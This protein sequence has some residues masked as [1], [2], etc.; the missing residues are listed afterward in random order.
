MAEVMESNS[1]RDELASLMEDTGIRFPAAGGDDD[2]DDA[3]G[4]STPAFE[5]KRSAAAA[6]FLFPESEAAKETESFKEQIKGFGKAW[7]EL[8]MELGRGCKEV[9]QQS[10]LTE[11]SYIVRKTKGPLS[12]VSKRLRFVNEYLPEDKDPVHAWSVILFVFILALAVLNVNN[13]RDTRGSEVKKVCI[14][15]PS[16]VRIL[17]PDGRYMA[18]QELGV[19]SDKARY[20]LIMPHGFLSSRLA[21]IPG[22][23][24][25]L[26]EE[27]GVRLITYD[28]P[29]FGESDSHPERNLNSSALDMAFLADS[30]GVN[31]KFWIIGYSSGAMHAWAAL[32]Y[33]PNR[34]SGAAMFAPLVNPYDSSMT[35]DEM[36][37]TWEKWVRRRKLMYGLARR[38]PMFLGS[39]YRRTFLAGK[40]GR[41][42]KWLSISLGEKDRALIE[43]PG[44][45]EFWHRDVEESI[46]QW[47]VKPFIEETV[48]QVSN[49]GFS[50]RDLQV[51]EKCDSSSI[52]P[53]LK[54]IYG[55][56][57]CELT[58]FLGPIHIWQGMDDHVVPPPMTDYVSRILPNAFV[59]KLPDEGHFSYFLFCDECHRQI[60]STLYGTP[61]GAIKTITETS[62]TEGVGEEASAVTYSTTE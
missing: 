10:L 9:A 29:G 3:I 59:H 26:L 43:E 19:P 6:A 15:P 32:K 58:G 5:G 27:F 48:L 17:L 52:F 23:K 31:G 46:R 13:T 30:V 51:K 28:L 7:G 39:M 40:H 41:I 50:L 1:W 8:L 11:D 4:V 21:G 62:T 49:W 55:Q 38:F 45:I 16:A 42:D 22:V 53:W 14:H 20:S 12:E 44:F 34:I 2:D 47:N 54:F 18:Y 60:L 25:S 37:G 36:T 35:R 57:K 61:Q 33:I 24:M 56:P